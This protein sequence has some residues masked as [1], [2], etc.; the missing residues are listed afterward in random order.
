MRSPVQPPSHRVHV[1]VDS[2]I[3][4]DNADRWK[5]IVDAFGGSVE[6]AFDALLVEATPGLRLGT[7]LN[8]HT[9]LQRLQRKV[10][11]LENSDKEFRSLVDQDLVRLTTRT[12]VALEQLEQS[13]Q[14]LRL[15]KA[16]IQ[17]SKARLANRD[18][19]RIT[20]EMYKALAKV[21]DMLGDLELA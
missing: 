14:S 4:V 11:K 18:H 12:D 10:E 1:Q 8:Y 15:L 9:N 5:E 2:R 16:S 7:P 3:S 21:E 13:A 17:H 6:L 20:G 19:D